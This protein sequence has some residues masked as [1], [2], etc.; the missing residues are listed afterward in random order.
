MTWLSFEV[1]QTVSMG[2][3]YS[4]TFSFWKMLLQN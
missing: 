1:T 4:Q 2:K 3:I